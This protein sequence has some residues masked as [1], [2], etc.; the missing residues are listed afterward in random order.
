MLFSKIF[1]IPNSISFAELFL[2]VSA[3]DSRVSKEHVLEKII[4]SDKPGNGSM[5]VDSGSPISLCEEF[6]AKYVIFFRFNE[7]M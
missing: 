7:G 6:N 5:E 4:I 3:Q 2:R 1:H